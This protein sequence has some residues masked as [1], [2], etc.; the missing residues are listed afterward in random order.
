MFGSFKRYIHFSYV[1]N[2]TLDTL[3]SK[4]DE[5][6]NQALLKRLKNLSV[7][8]GKKMT[9]NTNQTCSEERSRLPERSLTPQKLRKMTELYTNDPLIW[10]ASVLARVFRIPEDYCKHICRYVKPMIDWVSSK[11]GHVKLVEQRKIVIDLARF[12]TDESY[13]VVYKRIAFPD[14][15]QPSL[16]RKA[17]P[18]YREDQARDFQLGQTLC[19]SSILSDSYGGQDNWRLGTIQV[20][21]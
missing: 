12:K 9:P 21:S 5:Q 4:N 18:E 13:L 17:L 19:T 15:D 6:L 2:K 11:D 8:G 7:I 10:N 1:T 3:R 20:S 14:I 16:P